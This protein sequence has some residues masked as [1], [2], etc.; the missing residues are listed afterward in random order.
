VDGEMH[1]ISTSVFIII[2][3]N[4]NGD[5]GYEKL[6][7]HMLYDDAFIAYLNGAE[8]YRTKNI[9]NDVPGSAAAS[10]HEASGTFDE[11]DITAFVDELAIGPNVL[12]I[13]GINTSADS[14]DMLVLPKLLGGVFDE[15]LL[16]GHGSSAP[17]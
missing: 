14:S 6:K 10:G 4:L 3:F 13:H 17:E 1:G 11:Y 16:P 12:A 2:E 9:T 8:V 5:E 7:L 15:A